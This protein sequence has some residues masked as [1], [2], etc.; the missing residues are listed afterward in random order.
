MVN[1]GYPWLT[2]LKPKNVIT[3]RRIVRF[4]WFWK[5]SGSKFR[6]SADFDV[7]NIDFLIKKQDFDSCSGKKCDFS[8]DRRSHPKKL[9]TFWK[10]LRFFGPPFENRS[11]FNVFVWKNFDF[12][13]GIFPKNVSARRLSKRFGENKNLFKNRSKNL[14]QK[15]RGKNP[16]QKSSAKKPSQ[17]LQ[18][19]DSNFKTTTPKMGR[20]P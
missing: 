1:H 15:N 8:L 6:P 5:H 9:T 7:K 10:T 13:E 11:L 17:V 12:L 18:K 16:A 2:M 20:A 19:I 3:R 4:R 14:S